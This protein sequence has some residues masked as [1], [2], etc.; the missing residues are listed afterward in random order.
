[1]A[2]IH[3]QR[4]RAKIVEFLVEYA[5]FPCKKDWEWEPLPN[6]TDKTSGPGALTCSEAM[7]EFVAKKKQAKN[8]KRRK[9]QEKKITISCHVDDPLAL[10]RLNS[11]RSGSMTSWKRTATRRATKPSPKPTLWIG[12]T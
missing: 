3:D 7:A 10:T 4:T 12:S 8:E 5:G 1:M 11:T 9:K 6:H 2:K